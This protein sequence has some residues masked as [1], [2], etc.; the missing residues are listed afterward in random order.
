MLGFVFSKGI[1]SAAKLI[2]SYFVAHGIKMVANING[3]EINTTD[4]AGMVL[5]INTALKQLF[6]W[7]KTKWPGKFDWLP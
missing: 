2:V 1:K 3:V 5:A 4:E 6:A 7:M